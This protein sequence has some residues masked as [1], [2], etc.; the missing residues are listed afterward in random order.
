MIRTAFVTLSL[1]L[2]ASP[3]YAAKSPSNVG[4]YKSWSVWEYTEKS[5]KRCFIYANPTN[6]SP[7]R[8]DHGLVSFFVRS[9]VR[10]DL[11]S[12]ASFQVGYPFKEGSEARLVIDG[13]SFRLLT[14][15]K[16]A[17]LAT[18]AE[19]EQELLEAMKSGRSMTITAL[20]ARGN[21]TRYEFPLAGVTDAVK[22][23]RAVCP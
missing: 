4:T 17:W 9:T 10:K 22:R 3:A 14:S 20:S 11:K 2:V 5:A 21:E 15:D 16:G 7:D 19:R 23:L 13:A 12:E 6:A 18:G 8:L 1:I